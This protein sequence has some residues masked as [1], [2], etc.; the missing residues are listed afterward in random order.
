MTFQIHIDASLLN[1]DLDNNESQVFY[2]LTY[3]S[4]A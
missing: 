3:W 1:V 2:P 4:S